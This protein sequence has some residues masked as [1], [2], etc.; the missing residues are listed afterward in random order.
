MLNKVEEEVPSAS[1]VDKAGDK[2]LQD[3]VNISPRF[4]R[5]RFLQDFSD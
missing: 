4:L 1:D 3:T 5:L 2:E